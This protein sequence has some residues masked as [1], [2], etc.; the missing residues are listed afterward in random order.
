[1]NTTVETLR[2]ALERITRL[3]PAGD[4]ETCKTPRKL[5]EQMEVIALRALADTPP[6]PIDI[7]WKDTPQPALIQA[8]AML[9]P[10]CVDDGIRRTNSGKWAKVREDELRNLAAAY[11]TFRAIPSQTSELPNMLTGRARFLRDRGE[12][13]S[14]ELMESAATA[15]AHAWTGGGNRC[16]DDGYDGPICA[17][18]RL[19]DTTDTET[20]CKP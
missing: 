15:L 19:P 14:P 6:A 13:K 10:G 20:E 7:D 17:R 16:P 11:A 18:C 12:V 3:R 2:T 5:V 4:I 1:M 8:V 9:L